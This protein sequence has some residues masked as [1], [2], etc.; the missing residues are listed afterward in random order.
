MKISPL[1]VGLVFGLC[2]ALLH[3]AWGAAVALG[4]GQPVLD[5]VFWAHFVAPAYRVE[6]FQ[7]GRLSMLITL[8]FSAGL[9]LGLVGGWLWNKLVAPADQPAV[10]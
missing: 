10:E 2:L 4:W 3:A 7:A 5:F 6:P 1:G 9:A 8:T